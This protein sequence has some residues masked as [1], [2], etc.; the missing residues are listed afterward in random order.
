MFLGQYRHNID[1]KGRL[2]VPARFRELLGEGAYITMGFDNN[3]MVLTTGA[4]EAVQKRISQTPFTDPNARLLRR[5]LFSDADRV[6]P[7]KN[8]RI[9]LPGFLR[10]KTAL[11][12]EAVLVGV[13]DYFE[14]WAPEEWE[15]QSANL[16]DTSANAQRFIGLELTAA[17][18][19]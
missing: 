9:L 10:E 19:D 8:G 7:D 14:I 13:G 5:L 3:L 15:R 2:T 18:E 11:V 1:T 4:F 6:E 12:E 16:G 17:A